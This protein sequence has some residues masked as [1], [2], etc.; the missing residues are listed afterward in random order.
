MVAEVCTA[1]TTGAAWRCESV[2]RPVITAGRLS[3]W[4]R[5]SPRRP[6]QIEH[7]W[8]R[9]VTLRQRVTLSIAANPSAGYR[10]FSRRR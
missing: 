1:L 6:L 3:F 10:T 8:Y 5:E 7:R 4:P 2:A 9:G